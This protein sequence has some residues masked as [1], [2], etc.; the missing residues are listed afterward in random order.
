MTPVQA[1]HKCL[2]GGSAATRCHCKLLK[3]GFVTEQLWQ[4]KVVAKVVLLPIA[5]KAVQHNRFV[6]SKFFLNTKVHLGCVA[7]CRMQEYDR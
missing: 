6:H 1:Q 5:G 2:P 7:R 4:E 3:I